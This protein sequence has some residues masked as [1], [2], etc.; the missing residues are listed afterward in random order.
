MLSGLQAPAVAP[1]DPV[2][3]GVSQSL[4]RMAR[5]HLGSQ[6]RT[7][8]SWSWFLGHLGRCLLFHLPWGQSCPS[9][10]PPCLLCVVPAWSEPVSP[11]PEAGL[12]S[13][14]P[15]HTGAPVCPDIWS[16]PQLLPQDWGSAEWFPERLHHCPRPHFQAR[17]V[18]QTCPVSP[19]GVLGAGWE[20]AAAGRSVF[21]VACPCPTD[22]GLAHGGSPPARDLG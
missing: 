14:P 21:G 7:G 17:A 2:E 10:A 16:T 15:V 8:V 19:A 11:A 13:P 20:R 9:G 6:A 3:D 22:V 4:G 18:A 5:G 1:A 12:A